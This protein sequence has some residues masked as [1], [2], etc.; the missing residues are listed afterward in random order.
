MGYKS[1]AQRKAVH[2]SK[3]EKKGASMKRKVKQE[4]GKAGIQTTKTKNTSNKHKQKVKYTKSNERIKSVER[5]DGS[6]KQVVKNNPEYGGKKTISK[7]S[8]SGEKSFKVKGASMKKYGAS[9]KEFPEIK[10]GNEGKFTKWVEK[11]MPGMDTCK[12]ASKIM[13]S[14]TKKYSSSVVKMAN[15]ANN[16]GCKAKKDG[17]SMDHGKKGGASFNPKLRKAV[18][19]GKIK[20]KFADAVMRGSKK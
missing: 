18:A 12:A 17:S 5:A 1:D 6:R 10:K 3:A 20:G 11:N 9:K 4:V 13:R 16:F 19:D 8:T 7:T 15:Y 14:K 2:A